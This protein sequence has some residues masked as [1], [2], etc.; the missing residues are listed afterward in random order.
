MTRRS[1]SAGRT[2]RHF[3]AR[4]SGDPTASW[5]SEELLGA[6]AQG[7]ASV[8]FRA[9]PHR[10]PWARQWRPGP[11]QCRRAVSEATARDAREAQM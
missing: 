9:D 5:V 1:A 10:D 8:G 11:K 7:L 3:E 4:G 6:L 2:R